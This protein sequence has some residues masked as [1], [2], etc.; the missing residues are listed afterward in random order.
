[1]SYP[2]GLL[3]AFFDGADLAAGVGFLVGVGVE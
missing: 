1:V 2:E 3:E